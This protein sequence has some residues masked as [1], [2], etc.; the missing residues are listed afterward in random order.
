[1]SS[2]VEKT[3]TSWSPLSWKNF[4]IQ[5]MPNYADKAALEQAFRQ[6][7]SYPPLTTSW[8]IESLRK[9][10][11]Q[12]GRGEAFILQGG[13]CAERFEDCNP[14]HIVN[15]MK[16]LLQM[17][18]ILLHEMNLP[19][20]RIG[21][22]AGQY[23]KPRSS[24]TE[25]INGET[26]NSYR[27]DII[28][29][30]EAESINREARPERLVEGYHKAGLTL[31]FLRSLVDDGF[32]DLHHPETWELDF[33]Q[34]NTFYREYKDM[35]HSIQRAI[36]FMESLKDDRFNALQ[37]VDYYTS[38]EALNLW[39]E[40]AQ[41]RQVPRRDGWFNLSS[42]MVWIGNRTRQL[43][44]AHIEY[45]KGIRNPIGVKVGP[46][47]PEDE[48][49]AILDTL[50]P[51]NEEGKIVLISRMGR[52]KVAKE[53]PRLLRRIKA[54]GK[55][56]VWQVDPMHGNTFSTKNG[57]K[58][59]NFDDIL[60]DVKQTFAAHRAE[61]TYLGGVHLELTGNNVTECVGGAQGLNEDGLDLNYQTYC[62][63]RLNYEQSLEMAFL[64]AREWKAGYKKS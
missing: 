18:F 3:K 64:V 62:D 29:G 9:K 2:T 57:V 33:M 12:V 8:E 25:V 7:Q 51:T 59:R 37:K 56:V 46:G 22:I 20:V 17:S 34:G 35:V 6:L 24:D 14:K 1:M 54:E 15:L 23:A 32:A 30:F 39:Y 26:M 36:G 16:V 38:H 4:P 61:G 49:L 48:L 28:N 60:E 53:L 52:D 44:G 11:A 41:T 13:D 27:G 5:Q 45:C 21:R 43:D 40:S 50:N 63:P 42:H 55:N 58:T 19:I 10:L 47:L 31:N